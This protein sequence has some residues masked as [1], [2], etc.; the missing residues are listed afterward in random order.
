MLIE[1]ILQAQPL[2]HTVSMDDSPEPKML[3]QGPFRIPRA[4][5][6]RDICDDEIEQRETFPDTEHE[7]IEH[8][9]KL[10][11]ENSRLKD[12][13][14]EWRGSIGKMIEKPTTFLWNLGSPAQ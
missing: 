12:K 4:V 5:V 8:I 6:L 10:I 11:E 2:R 13:I 1:Y 14:K 7:G 3:G 9:T